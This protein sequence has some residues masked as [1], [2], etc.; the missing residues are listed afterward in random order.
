MSLSNCS[1][2]RTVNTA[3][4]FT[5]GQPSHPSSAAMEALNSIDRCFSPEIIWSCPSKG[6]SSLLASSSM[7]A[8]RITVSTQLCSYPGGHVLML[9]LLA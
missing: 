7:V 9:L 5:S 8:V 1:Q 2:Q 6:T 3:P 4:S